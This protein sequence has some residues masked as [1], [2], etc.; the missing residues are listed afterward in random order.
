MSLVMENLN[1]HS[2]AECSKVFAAGSKYPKH[3]HEEY[4]VSANLA[5]HEKIWFGG[6]SAEVRPNQITIYNPLTIQA[7]EFCPGGTQFISV[8]LEAYQM[9][10]ML[11]EV[12]ISR[13]TAIFKEGVADDSRFFDTI[14]GLYVSSSLVE[15]EEALYSFMAEL[16]RFK[17]EPSMNIEPIRVTRIVTFMQENL[18]EEINLEDLCAEAN[19]SKFHLVRS[20]KNSKGLPPMQYFNQLKLIEAR[21]RLRKGESSAPVA[22]E[23]GFFDQGHLCNSFRKVMGISPGKYVS[24]LES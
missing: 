16:A 11:N 12:G 19:L 15:R 4:V 1:K 5:G 6:L 2:F 23:L 13:G 3:T 24:M 8:H 9:N 20:F 21:K 17:I 7:S 10:A 22:A 18:Y 14:V